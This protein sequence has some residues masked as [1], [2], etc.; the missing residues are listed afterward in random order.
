MEKD[1]DN[2]VKQLEAL[3]KRVQRL[4]KQESE[5]KSELIIMLTR[6]CGQWWI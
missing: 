1:T 5:D 3:T 2:L 4:E 6:W